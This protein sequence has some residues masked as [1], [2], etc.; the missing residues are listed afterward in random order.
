MFVNNAFIVILLFLEKKKVKITALSLWMWSS[1]LYAEISIRRK[2][3]VSQ[4]GNRHKDSF[5]VVSLKGGK[6]KKSPGW[7]KVTRHDEP[8]YMALLKY[9]LSI[10]GKRLHQ[11]NKTYLC[12]IIVLAS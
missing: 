11:V 10:D 4:R 2:Y 12:I 5:A 7:T 8:P 9:S 3:T 6:R 1:S